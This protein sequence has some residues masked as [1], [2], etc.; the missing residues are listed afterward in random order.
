M[1]FV[2]VDKITRTPTSFEVKVA[3]ELVP[4]DK[5]EESLLDKFF[6]KVTITDVFSVGE[7]EKIKSI[8]SEDVKGVNYR[9]DL[10]KYNE[11][12]YANYAFQIGTETV[13]CWFVKP[14]TMYD[15]EKAR[16]VIK[17]SIER[18]IA[19]K[20]MGFKFDELQEKIKTV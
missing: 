2:K 4:K 19:Q 11:D 15:K 9:I 14:K 8:V 20:D 1:P 17:A 12:G 18:G 10:Q 5:Q 16:T 13:A 7:G 6:K 3:L